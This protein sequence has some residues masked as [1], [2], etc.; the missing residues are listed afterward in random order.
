MRFTDELGELVVDVPCS[1]SAAVQLRWQDQTR[2]IEL[3]VEPMNAPSTCLIVGTWRITGADIWDREYLDLSGP[4]RF[5]INR[6]GRGK[7]AF[8]AMEA[9][10]DIEYGRSMIFYT[11]MGF[12]EGDEVRGTGS[13]ELV[14]DG[15]NRPG[16]AGG[17]NS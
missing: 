13:A 3:A 6:D 9:R 14:D 12:D 4:A 10:M 17:S 16:F 15:L 1:A 8:G 2:S 5:V 7:I 11:W